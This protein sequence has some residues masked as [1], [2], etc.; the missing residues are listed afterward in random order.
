MSPRRR[1]SAAAVFAALAALS[2]WLFQNASLTRLRAEFIPWMHRLERYRDALE[3]ARAALRARG[4]QQGDPE[5]IAELRAW[6]WKDLDRV[7]IVSFDVEGKPEMERKKEREKEKDKDFL[8]VWELR[9]TATFI[10]DGFRADGAR[11]E[12]AARVA[13]VLPNADAPAGPPTGRRA[14]A[15]SPSP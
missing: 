1:W 10:V 4:A 15:A 3:T 6:A 8:E 11:V 7:A 5:G 9:G 13:F 14:P 2:V 12:R